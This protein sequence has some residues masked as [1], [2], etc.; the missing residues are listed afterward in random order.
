MRRQRDQILYQARRIQ[1]GSQG[2]RLGPADAD[3]GSV[4]HTSDCSALPPV[5]KWQGVSVHKA[6]LCAVNRRR[7]RLDRLY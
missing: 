5:E 2:E 1:C 7:L 3:G 4:S 6:I